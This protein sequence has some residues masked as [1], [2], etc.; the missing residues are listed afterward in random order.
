MIKVV[1][2]TED[3][4]EFK[5]SKENIDMTLLNIKEASEFL[6]V[7]TG[8]LYQWKSEGKIPFVKING[9]LCFKKQTLIEF[10]SIEV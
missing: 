3:R 4:K 8:T 9:R 6:K 5:D 2:N 1:T 7:A 10:F